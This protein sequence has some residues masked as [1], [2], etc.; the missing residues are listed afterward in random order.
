MVNAGLLLTHLITAYI[1]MQ[2]INGFLA[3][4]EVPDWASSL[5]RASNEPQPGVVGNTAF[6]EKVGYESA[7]LEWHSAEINKVSG[8]PS[9]DASTSPNHGSNV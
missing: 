5:K 8:G 3:E 7:T 9:G 4:E 6:Q 1:S 2:R